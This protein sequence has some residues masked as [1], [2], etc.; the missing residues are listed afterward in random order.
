MLEIKP[1]CTQTMTRPMGLGW[2]MPLFADPTP[3]VMDEHLVRMWQRCE[4]QVKQIQA[5]FVVKVLEALIVDQHF[6][7]ELLVDDV[8]MAGAG[9]E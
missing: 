1:I 8:G 2:P 5:R 9:S 7:A 4:G 6:H 3:F